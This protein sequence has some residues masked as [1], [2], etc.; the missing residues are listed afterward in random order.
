MQDLMSYELRDF[1]MFSAETY[2]SLH[3][4]LVASYWSLSL[5][6]TGLLIAGLYMAIRAGRY[7]LLLVVA[8]VACLTSAYLFHWQA[9]GE[10]MLSAPYYAGLFVLIA[11]QLLL[12]LKAQ[13]P[14]PAS[15]VG[16]F[17][18]FYSLILHPFTG[19]LLRRGEGSFDL[20]GIG[21][22]ATLMVALGALVLVRAPR[23]QYL[24]PQVWCL[25]SGVTLYGLEDPAYLTVMLFAMIALP[26]GW[27]AFDRGQSQ[28]EA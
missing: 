25:V 21:P 27:Q 6:F 7:A 1:L 28:P 23:W 8:A 2:W 19:V 11:F 3:A 5:V 13:E 26:F 22:D 17:L 15:K 14:R 16:M 20:V 24:L 9:Y 10:I 18:V 12:N 4:D